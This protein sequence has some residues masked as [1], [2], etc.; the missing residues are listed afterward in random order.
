MEGDN[1]GPGDGRDQLQDHGLP[2]HTAPTTG[3]GAKKTDATTAIMD[4]LLETATGSVSAP[5]AATSGMAEP[6]CST[7]D[8]TWSQASSGSS[9]IQTSQN[10]R[11]FRQ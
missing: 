3:E 7:R 8:R 2:Q 4:S 1:D 6:V 5:T 10:N 9:D 11:D